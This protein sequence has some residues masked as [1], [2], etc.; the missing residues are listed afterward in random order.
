MSIYTV[1]RIKGNQRPHPDFKAKGLD[2]LHPCSL[3][4]C[5]IYGVPHKR[6]IAYAAYVHSISA[7]LF[8]TE[9]QVRV[10]V[11]AE[12]YPIK[13]ASDKVLGTFNLPPLGVSFKKK[14]SVDKITEME[15][16]YGMRFVKNMGQ[17]IYIIDNSSLAVAKAMVEQDSI[18]DART[19]S[20]VAN[21]FGFQSYLHCMKVVTLFCVRLLLFRFHQFVDS[22]LVNA[23]LSRFLHSFVGSRDDPQFRCR[24]GNTHS[25]RRGTRQ[26]QEKEGSA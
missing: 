3:S 18:R 1:R 14:P 8:A 22:L 15:N 25:T 4:N 23:Y 21:L 5:E 17:D 10:S 9:K 19:P 6:Q 7:F 11:D 16:Q 26:Q 20:G 2:A 13:L 12:G 24:F